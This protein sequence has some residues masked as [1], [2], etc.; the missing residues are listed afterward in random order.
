MPAPNIQR[1]NELTGLI[2]AH[3]YEH[4]PTPV[5]LEP[6]MF[7]FQPPEPR[8]AGPA[9][10]LMVPEQTADEVFFVST[11]SWLAD[12]GYI[13]SKGKGYGYYLPDARLTAKG[14]EVLNAFPAPLT[15]GP[16]LGEKMLD[17]SKSGAKVVLSGAVTE[18]LGI[19]ARLLFS[20]FGLPD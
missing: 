6:S 3:L 17:A 16:T 7:G 19:G 15:V 8:P 1:F 12:A 5:G 2:L 4:F 10:M 20:Q 18:A 11:A 9:G 13:S 14:L